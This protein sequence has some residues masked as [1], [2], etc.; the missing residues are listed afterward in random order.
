MIL[1]WDA[2]QGDDS[3]TVKAFFGAIRSSIALLQERLGD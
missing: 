2:E 1:N 3:E